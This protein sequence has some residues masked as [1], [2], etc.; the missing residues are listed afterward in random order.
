MR[1]RHE[2]NIC[3]DSLLLLAFGSS[4]IAIALIMYDKP[5]AARAKLINILVIIV[6]SKDILNTRALNIIPHNGLHNTKP[7]CL[8]NSALNLM[9]EFLL[10]WK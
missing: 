6:S 9:L 10:I 7:K 3:P 2:I 8:Y 5:I 4:I 1:F